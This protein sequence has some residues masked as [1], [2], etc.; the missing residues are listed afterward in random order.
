MNG[1]ESGYMDADFLPSLDEGGRD[2]EAYIN[3]MLHTKRQCHPDFV[4]KWH[5]DP[6]AGT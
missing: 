5:G 6:E 4:C 1:H 3:G 2:E